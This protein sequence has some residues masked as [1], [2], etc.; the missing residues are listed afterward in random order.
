MIA[1]EFA[2]AR[3]HQKPLLLH[4]DLPKSDALSVC[5]QLKRSIDPV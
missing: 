3:H 4:G 2:A 5:G 1:R